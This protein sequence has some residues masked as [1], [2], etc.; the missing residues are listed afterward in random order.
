MFPRCRSYENLKGGNISEALLDLTVPWL[1]RY[2]A[3]CSVTLPVVPV[4]MQGAPVEDY[5]LT[6][7]EVTS[8]CLSPRVLLLAFDA[9]S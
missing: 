4:R 9:R 7:T 8:T 1:F 2:P 3:N 6:C 5:N